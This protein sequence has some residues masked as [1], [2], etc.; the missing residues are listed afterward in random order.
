ML[1]FPHFRAPAAN[2]LK[3]RRNI[4]LPSLVNLQ[5]TAVHS[6]DNSLQKFRIKIGVNDWITDY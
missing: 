3:T 2:I 5:V 1:P 6:V 4:Q